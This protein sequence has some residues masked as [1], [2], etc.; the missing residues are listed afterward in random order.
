ME[1]DPMGVMVKTW[2]NKIALCI[3]DLLDQEEVPSESSISS[4]KPDN[5]LKWQNCPFKKSSYDSD[6]F[7]RF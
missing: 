3:E 2:N 6:A 1:E 4:K 5:V 7:Y